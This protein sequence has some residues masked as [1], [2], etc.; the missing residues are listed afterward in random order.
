MDPLLITLLSVIAS[1]CTCLTVAKLGYDYRIVK[2][3]ARHGPDNSLSKAELRELIR[4]TLEER[5]APLEEQVRSLDERTGGSD[6]YLLT[7]AGESSRRMR[8]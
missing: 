2:L 4:E 3:R 7:E 6:G 1:C 8:S 5:I